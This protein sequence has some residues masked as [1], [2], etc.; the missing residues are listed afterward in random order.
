MNKIERIE[1]KKLAG[2]VIRTNNSGSVYE[3]VA[4]I[5]EDDGKF[6]VEFPDV[7]GVWTWADTLEEAKIYA[8]D[9]LRLTLDSMREEK[10][11]FPEAKTRPDQSKNLYIIKTVVEDQ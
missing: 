2:N 11:S 6:S 7:Q 9:A 4:H 3:Y 8:E 1:D 5:Y 10:I